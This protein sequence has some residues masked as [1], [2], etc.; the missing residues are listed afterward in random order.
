MKK[1][2]AYTLGWDTER[3]QGYLTLVDEYSQTHAFGELS[4]EEFAMLTQMLKENR[5]CIDNNHWIITGWNPDTH[6]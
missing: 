5:V 3:K 2:I 1:V 6:H 4:A